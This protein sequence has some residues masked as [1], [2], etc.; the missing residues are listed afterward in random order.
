M[1]RR[2]RRKLRRL[3][4]FS[5]LG[6]VGVVG[7]FTLG[8]A[9]AFLVAQLDRPF[10]DRSFDEVAWKE[11]H[12]AAYADNPRGLMADSL[13]QRLS[14]GPMTRADVINLLG[15]PDFMSEAEKKRQDLLSYNLGMWSGLRTGYNSLDIILDAEGRVSG[16]HIAHH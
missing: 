7:A 12:G 5:A 4:K 6:L 10:D 9:I 14:N 16:T 1:R 8:G 2:S 11:H 15:E 13:V 3:L